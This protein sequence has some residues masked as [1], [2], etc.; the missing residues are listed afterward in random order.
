MHDGHE[1][2]QSIMR[3][4]AVSSNDEKRE[5]IEDKRQKRSE[6]KKYA[7]K[8][9]SLIST[10]LT[11]V[12]FLI[13]MCRLIGLSDAVLIALLTT[14]TTTVIGVFVIVIKYLFPNK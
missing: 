14:T 7:D 5:E 8:T 1:S 11:L 13:C 3:E 6:R 9:F 4:E 2:S 12:F 10:Y